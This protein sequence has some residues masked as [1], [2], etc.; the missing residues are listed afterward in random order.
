[1]LFSPANHG[2]RRAY[3]YLLLG[4]N[5]VQLIDAGDWLVAVTDDNISFEDR[6]PLRRTAS[7]NG[8][9]QNPTLHRQV[10][11]PYDT[12]MQGNVLTSQADVAAPDFAFLNELP[13]DK[14]RSVYGDK[15]SRCPERAG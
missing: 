3:T 11:I 10:V 8:D 2:Q 14:L 15:R 6:S 1:M 9:H 12:T 4:Q 13:G 5:A 7:F